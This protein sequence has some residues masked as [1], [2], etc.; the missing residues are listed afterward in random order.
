MWSLA[1]WSFEP[2][3]VFALLA[4]SLGYAVGLIRLRPRTVWDEHVVAPR[5]VIAFASG[6][7]LLVVALISPLD[8]LSDTLFTAHMFQHMLLMYAVP[9]L[10]LVGTPAWLLRPALAVP[11]IERALRFLTGPIAAVVVFNAVLVFW[12]MPSAWD[13]ALVDRSVHAL[14]HVGFFGAGLIAWWPIFSPLPEVPR[15]SYPGQMLYL[16]VQ[17]LVPAVVGAFLTF[18]GVVV[19]PVYAMTPKLWGLTPLIDQR[20]A[21]FEMKLLGTVLLWV[22]VTVRF[23]QW[24]SHEEHELEKVVDDAPVSE[25]H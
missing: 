24:F 4:L 12:H 2:G 7:A 23:F 21:G 19:Y 6:I 9:P 13:A 22:L 8:T 16:F 1:R 20:L 25:R 10:L 17:S 14:E 18:S 3:V 11:G 15:L 5:E